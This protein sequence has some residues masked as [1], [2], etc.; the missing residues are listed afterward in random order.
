MSEP[1]RTSPV[2]AAP[3][4]MTAAGPA[5]SARLRVV[6]LSCLA[7]FLLTVVWSAEFVDRVIGFGVMDTLLGE[8]AAEQPI[9]GVAAGVLFA[10]VSGLAGTFTA[11]NVAVFG[12]VAPLMS[13]GGTWRAAA[14]RALGPMAWLSA[15]T[16]AVSAGYG[17]IVG[18]AGTSMPQFSTAQNV[19]GALSARSVQSMVVFGV[20]GL[21]L[22]YLGL[23]ALGLAP[24]PFARFPRARVVFLGALIGG[25]LI[26]RPYPLFRELFR[27]AAQSGNPLYG[28]AA[29]V[30][31]SLGNIVVMAVLAV[32]LARFGGGLARRLSGRTAL[33][34]GAALI[35]AGVFLFLYWDVRLLARREI[36]PWYPTAPWS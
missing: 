36:I 30:L 8:G 4:P 25:F 28:A 31:Q 35:I 19:A 16:V 20:I 9:A 11:C 33:V 22:F 6:V 34:T 10:F 13:T 3:G 17:A 12:A 29:F 14:A 7:G 15:G 32:L 18:L 5:P 26:G 24:D 2:P 27:D 23:A 21:V 1:T